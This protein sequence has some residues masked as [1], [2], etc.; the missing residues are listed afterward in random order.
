MPS[1]TISGA[2]GG[3]LVTARWSF[4]GNDLARKLR[5]AQSNTWTNYAM[6]L[7][8]LKTPIQ[9][10]L[11]VNIHRQSIVGDARRAAA[12]QAD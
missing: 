3:V 7:P 9:D 10:S 2:G 8:D 1:P 4:A 12:A 6:P 11:L 5:N